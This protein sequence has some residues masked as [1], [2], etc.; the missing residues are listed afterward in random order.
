LV[1]REVPFSLKM[2]VRRL[3]P[4]HA[5]LRRA[6]AADPRWAEGTWARALDESWVLVQGRIDCLFRCDNR[7]SVLD[8]K[9]DRLGPDEIAERARAYRVQMGL[10]RE[11][12]TGLWGVPGQSWLVFVAAGEAVEVGA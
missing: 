6:I 8:W 9:T 11:A 5:E 7:W 10:Y 1:E 12:V 2:P 3:L 4:M